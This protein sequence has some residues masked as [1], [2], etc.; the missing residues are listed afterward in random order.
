MRQFNRSINRSIHRELLLAVI[1]A[2]L[3]PASIIAVYSISRTEALLTELKSAQELRLVESRAADMGRFLTT[4]RADL[5]FLSRSPEVR[6]FVNLHDGDVTS[7]EDLVLADIENLLH[8]YLNRQLNAILRACLIDG[9]G[10]EQLCVHR[11]DDGAAI[12]PAELLTSQ[13]DED[14]FEVVLNNMGDD[15]Q[16]VYIEDYRLA[17]AHIDDEVEQPAS[18]YINVLHTD[19]GSVAGTLVLEVRLEPV[20]QI[21]TED[22]GESTVLLLDHRG[23][24]IYDS[25]NKDLSVEGRVNFRRQYPDDARLILGQPSGVLVGSPN[26]R[27]WLSSF[28]TVSFPGESDRAWTVIYSQPLSSFLD[29]V[30]ESQ[31]VIVLIAGVSLFV[32][33]WVAVIVIRNFTL[34]I[35][36]LAQAA[37]AVNSEQW[38]VSVPK[39]NRTDELGDLARAFTNMITRLRNLFAEQAQRIHELQKAHTSL[40]QSE[41]RFAAAFENSPLGI[42]VLNAR[43]GRFLDANEQFCAIAGYTREAILGRTT[44]DL[45]LWVDAEQRAA[46]FDKLQAEGMVRNVDM[47]LRRSGGE[48]RSLLTSFTMMEVDGEPYIFGVGADITERKS[49]EDQLRQQNRALATLNQIATTLSESPDL[50]LEQVLIQIATLIPYDRAGI[51]LSQHDTLFIAAAQDASAIHRMGKLDAV[52][53]DD[54]VRLVFEQRRMETN[55]AHT[56]AESDMQSWMG[57]PL[58]YL[59]DCFGVLIFEKAEPYFYNAVHMQQALTVVRQLAAAIENVR[60]FSRVL[61]Y[62]IEL[63]DRVTERTAELEE[64]NRKLRQIDS[65]KTRFISD[66][67]HELRTPISVLNTRMYLLEKSQGQDGLQ[68]HIRILKTHL[69]HLI[70]LT[71][72]VLDLSRLDLMKKD[73]DYEPVDLNVIAARIV[74]AYQPIA[75]DAGLM[76]EVEFAENLPHIVGEP[77]QLIQVVTNL[78]TNAIRYTPAGKIVVKTA[79]DRPQETVCLIVIDTGLGIDEDETPHIFDR[80]FRSRNVVQSAIPGTGLGLAI[81]REIVELHG[82][83]IDVSSK[84]QEGTTFT[85]HFPAHV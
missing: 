13:A 16:P 74:D 19:S 64:A 54:R 44:D 50:E 69:N 27:D 9:D 85:L 47:L 57:I 72:N 68:K 30:R 39:L 63:E 28:A 78:I 32:V 17:H 40:R 55:T 41:E 83:H 76:L 49:M 77:N 20:V 46:V 6:R 84:P 66:V 8:A 25:T 75:T 12:T 58:L 33:I 37:N 4:A 38:D 60:L 71:E 10:M 43:N 82:G 21:I 18:H 24:P 53:V 7:D 79:Y 35:T 22:T 34:P 36:A 73:V 15:Q 81:V 31:M 5:R 2:T 67:A 14:Y 70:Q 51:A 62:S 80:F 29:P 23:M 3:I 48:V 45:K 59:D 1:L 52:K 65:M 11:T 56:S 61:D 26:R 42:S